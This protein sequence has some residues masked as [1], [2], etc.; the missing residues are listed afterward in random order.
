MTVPYDISS[1]LGNRKSM[2]KRSRDRQEVEKRELVMTSSRRFIGG[3]ACF[4]YTARLVT[5]LTRRPYS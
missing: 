4:E 1:G 3:Y 5:Q 2:G